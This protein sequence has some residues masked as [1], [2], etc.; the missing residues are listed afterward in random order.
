MV[1]H[2]QRQILALLFSLALAPASLFAAPVAATAD[3]KTYNSDKGEYA[4]KY[5]E[6]LHVGMDSGQ[7]CVNNVCKPIE[8]ISLRYL[9]NSDLAKPMVRNISF[10]VQRNM[11]PNALPIDKL[12][13]SLSHKP[14]GPNET[15]IAVG[16]KKAVRRG[17][18]TPTQKVTVPI[19]PDGKTPT[20]TLGGKNAQPNSI[21]G[22][23]DYYIPLN[24]TDILTTHCGST[25]SLFDETCRTIVLT[26]AF[27]K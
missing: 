10:T 27:L 14:L 26:L 3:W 5:P 23:Y 22:T 6:W 2:S 8:A 18:N 9:D 12:Y 13:E 16:G 19:G 20:V 17:P 1:F 15:V 21:S 4:F 11:N 24:A 7:T 25:G